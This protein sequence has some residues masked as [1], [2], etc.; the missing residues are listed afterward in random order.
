MHSIILF[1]SLLTFSF[2]C[3][4]NQEIKGQ[5][6][7][8]F[9]IENESQIGDPP[10]KGS[11]S[12]DSKAQR[13][14]LEGSGENIWFDKDQFYF[15]WKAIE[16]DFILQSRIRFPAES[17]HEHTKIGIM[18]R[19]S[20]DPGASHYSGVVHADG[21]TSLQYRE[22]KNNQTQEVKSKH[23][24]PEVI[25]LEKKGQDITFSFAGK[26]EVF[27]SIELTANNFPG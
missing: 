9:Q 25:Q 24:M 27:R 17:G 6:V 20:M 4:M 14:L 10:L 19:E 2:T 1:S 8:P 5:A 21:L 18:M 26:G 22:T 16:G 12:Y 15:A 7:I 13:Y 11:F 23:I 3:F